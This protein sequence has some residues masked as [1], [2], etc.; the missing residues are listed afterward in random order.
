MHTFVA[1]WLER[2]ICNAVST[3]LSLVLESYCVGTL[4][5]QFLCSITVSVT[6]MHVL[7]T[8]CKM[9]DIKDQLIVFLLQL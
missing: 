8:F 7:W 4:S 9:G 3:V 5:T 2:S 1:D 6:L